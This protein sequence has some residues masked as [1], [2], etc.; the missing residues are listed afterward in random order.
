MRHG[1]TV[2]NLEGR[3]QGHLD[4]PLTERGL[5]QAQALAERLARSPCVALYSSDL[6][7]AAQTARLVAGKTGHPIVFD[8]RLRERALGVF[9]GL[10]R[11]QVQDRFPGEY[12]R[13]KAAD[14]DYVVPQGESA[15]QRLDAVVA[16]VEELALRHAGQR[17]VLVTHGGV[18]SALFRHVLRIPPG[19]PRR[20]GRANATWNVFAHVEGKWFVETWGDTSHLAEA[21]NA[22]DF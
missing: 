9:E 7:R 21:G 3:Y 15:R 17:V 6:G 4:S 5:V 19:A 14:L 13:L 1:E 8:S 18:L 12:H 11:T 16:C 2:W 22:S 10:T 20:F